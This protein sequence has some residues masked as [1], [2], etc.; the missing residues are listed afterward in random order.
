MDLPQDVY[1]G[2]AEV[3]EQERMRDAEDGVFIARIL[4]GYIKRKVQIGYKS[5][6]FD[7]AQLDY[8]YGFIPITLHL[9]KC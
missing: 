6:V 2:I 3:V 4:E 7:L 9:V 8:I 5:Y 1:S